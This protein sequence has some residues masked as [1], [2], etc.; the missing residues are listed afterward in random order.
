VVL[1]IRLSSILRRRAARDI[2]LHD[3]PPAWPHLRPAGALAGLIRDVDQT[4]DCPS[5]R[6]G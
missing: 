3:T 2:A 5:W 6:P 1:A 4:S